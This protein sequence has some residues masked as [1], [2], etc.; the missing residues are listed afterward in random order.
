MWVVLMRRATG[1]RGRARRRWSASRSGSPASRCCC[2]RAAAA[3]RPS[4]SGSSS[5]SC[6]SLSWATGIV[7]SSRVAAAV[8]PVPVDRA[9]DDP[10]RAASARR[11]GWRSARPARSTSTRS[12][13][14]PCS[15]A[16]TWSS[17]GRWSRSPRTSWL[18]Q[19]APISKVATYAYVN[20]VIA[21]L[22][23]CADPVARTITLT[24]LAGAPSSWR[25]WR[26]SSAQESRLMWLQQE[27]A[28]D[29]AAARLPPRDRRGRATAVPELR[30]AARRDRARLHPAH[31][32]VADAERERVARRA[33]RLPRVVRP[34][35]AGRR[36]DYFAHTLEGPDDMPAHIK[37]SL[38]G[39]SLTLPVPTAAS[40][41]A[42]G[43]AS[44]CAS[45]ATAA[46]RARC[47]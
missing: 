15:P 39:P 6:A 27:V 30:D 34:R 9:A 33:P 40:R 23:G 10:R 46:A 2:C 16:S 42:P 29:A 47:W 43:R 19:N 7:P 8:E 5:C 37:S 20:P 26:R 24:I 28:L 13:P 36:A 3:T 12:R 21:I 45:T 18:L 35:G 31:V 14:T 11:S 4:R 44:T 17:S 25:R 41:S 32:G 1:E 22:L 38:L